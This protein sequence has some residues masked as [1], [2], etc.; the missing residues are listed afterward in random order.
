MHKTLRVEIRKNTITIILD[1]IQFE[2]IQLY[3]P[4]FY[5]IFE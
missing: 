5:N 3:L 2:V 4:A 1:Y